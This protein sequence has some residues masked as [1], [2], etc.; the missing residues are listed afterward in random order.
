MPIALSRGLAGLV[1]LLAALAAGPA[2]AQDKYPARPI[3]LIVPTPPGGGTDTLARQL[4]EVMEPILG[5]KLVVENKPGGG[6][7]V[8]TTL[9]SQGRPDG[10]TLGMIWNG[11]ITTA[12]HTLQVPY[13]PESYTPI[14]QIGSSSYVMCVAP[15]F[16]ASNAKEFVQA[17]RQAPGKYTYG[18][19][20]VGGTMQ[21]AAERIFKALG[22]KA[23]PVPFGGAGETLRNFLGGHVDIYGGSLPP[24]L[25]HVAAGKA[26]CLLLTSADDNPAVPQASGLKAL[27]IGDL[28]TVLWWGV[29]GPKGLPRS[30]V[31]RLEAVFRKAAES[32]QIQQALDKIGARPLV[33]GP[34]EMAQ[35]IRSESAALGEIAKDL[36]LERRAQ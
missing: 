29:I 24:V 15:E 6:G 30:L 7:T 25:P 9:V 18:N 26:K 14:V 1:G 32:P 35:L 16:P 19:D 31:D 27:G 13:T 36:G 17:L 12:P 5:T 11:P 10:Y 3:T 23:R 34:Q 33:R 8:G 2:P 4:A 21:L 22:V 28:E 20:G